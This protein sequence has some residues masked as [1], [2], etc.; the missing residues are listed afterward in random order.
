MALP[1]VVWR[2]DMHPITHAAAHA[3]SMW[4]AAFLHLASSTGP[5]DEGTVILGAASVSVLIR[6]SLR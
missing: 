1:L 3:L 5:R 2:C 4:T 6:P